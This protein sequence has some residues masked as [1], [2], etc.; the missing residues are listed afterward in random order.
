MRRNLSVQSCS[1]LQP[2][3]IERGAL[4]TFCT[5]MNRV[6]HRSQRMLGRC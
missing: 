4:V 6:T 5:R 3:N 1:D 2:A